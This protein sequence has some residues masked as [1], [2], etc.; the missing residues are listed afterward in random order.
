[1]AT[2][3]KLVWIISPVAGLM[4]LFACGLS[5]PELNV[6]GRPPGPSGLPS[7]RDGRVAPPARGGNLD[8]T[9]ASQAGPWNDSLSGLLRDIDAETDPMRRESLI[10]AAVDAVP[11]GDTR[12]AL[13][14]LWEIQGA[15][16]SGKEL[17]SR[18]A[19]R[20]AEEDAPDAAKWIQ[21][22]APGP[23]REIALDQAAIAWASVDLPGVMEWARSMS[24][25][26][27]GERVMRQTAYEASRSSP[28]EALGLAVE[29]PAGNA[30]NNLIIHACLQW[31]G[32]DGAGA[33]EWAG[34]IEDRLLRERALAAIA[35]SWAGQNPHEAACLAAE[36]LPE[37]HQQN[38]AVAAIV[39]RWAR[40]EPAKAAE[41]VS[42]FD[43]SPVKTAAMKTL[44][45]VSKSKGPAGMKAGQ[46][47]P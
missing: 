25:D 31:A 29:L 30:R 11:A 21:A 45:A 2:Q 27:D 39:Q 9:A 17:V 38:R 4:I 7:S 24:G 6:D 33:A 20:W 22:S 10:A 12:A 26:P 46:A 44:L 37:G 1:M 34:Q 8:P 32:T 40:M 36:A 23:L 43:D 13:A 3:R 5:G 15:T 47:V 14:R 19:R 16:A 28:V 42:G 41:W 35:T 18:L